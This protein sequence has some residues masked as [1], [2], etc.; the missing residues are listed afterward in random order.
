MWQKLKHII[1]ELRPAAQTVKCVSG[2]WGE[3]C[4]ARYLQQHGYIISARQ[5]RVGRHD[6]IDI[7]AYKDET[8]VFVE[9]KTRRTENFGRPMA[10]VTNKKRRFLSRAATRYMQRMRVA[11]DYFRFDVIEVIGTP[12]AAQPPQIRHIENAFPLDRRYRYG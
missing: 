6:E 9:V 1:D 7:I 2:S 10:A 12:E 8:L 3:D 11:P 5:Q 4:A